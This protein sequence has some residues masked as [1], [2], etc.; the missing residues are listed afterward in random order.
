[1]GTQNKPN[2]N[3]EP[4]SPPRHPPLCPLC[5]RVSSPL[6]EALHLEKRGNPNLQHP[7]WVF[8]LRHLLEEKFGYPKHYKAPK[9]GMRPPVGDNL[10]R[11]MYVTEQNLELMVDALE[12]LRETLDSFEKAAKGA[13]L[14]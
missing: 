13:K 11:Y 7:K 9:M 10:R 5:T 14:I 1:M 8:H 3:R 4:K 6:R 2:S 12:V